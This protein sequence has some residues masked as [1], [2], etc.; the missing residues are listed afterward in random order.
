MTGEREREEPVSPVYG[1]SSMSMIGV[2]VHS[3]ARVCVNVLLQSC[4]SARL[5]V[6]ES[7]VLERT[8]R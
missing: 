6:M 4:R 1:L 7:T 8:K 5:S 2:S 3:R